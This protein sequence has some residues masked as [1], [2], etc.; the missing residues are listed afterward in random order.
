MISL[1][2]WLWKWKS[3]TVWQSY[4]YR[5]SLFWFTFH[6]F[7]FTL[8]ISYEITA[9]GHHSLKE[10]ERLWSWTCGW[11]WTCCNYCK[12]P[13]SSRVPDKRRVLDTGRGSRQIV[14]IED[15]SRINAGSRI[16]AVLT[17][18]TCRTTTSF[19]L[20]EEQNGFWKCKKK[21]MLWFA[22]HRVVQS[23]SSRKHFTS[24]IA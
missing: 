14:L 16:Q 22:E 3:A 6:L 13:D 20:I 12:S 15:G 9:S 24:D 4:V 10:S 1:R 18:E 7:N 19:R 2:L 23:I 8:N 11:S 21:K 17:V 5:G